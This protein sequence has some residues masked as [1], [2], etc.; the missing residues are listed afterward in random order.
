[1]EVNIKNFKYI[2]DVI[3]QK[4]QMYQYYFDGLHLFFPLANLKPVSNDEKII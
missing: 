2:D 3:D 1:M 4:Y